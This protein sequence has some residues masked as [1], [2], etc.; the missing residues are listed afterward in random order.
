MESW[1]YGPICASFLSLETQFLNGTFPNSV[2]L[3]IGKY[4]SSLMEVFD[5]EYK[6]N[7]DGWMTY[8]KAD[9]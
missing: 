8:R 1:N 4:S 2:V 3:I 7:S 9:T 5:T 6:N